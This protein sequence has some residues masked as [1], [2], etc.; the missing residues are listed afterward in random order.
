VL[1]VEVVPL[2]VAAET[3]AKGMVEEVAIP[4][5]HQQR[6]KAVVATLECHARS[7]ARQTMMHCS[8]GTGLIRH[9]KLKT[10]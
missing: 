8:V 9:I 1:F 3:V 4:A 10:Q 5:G 2:V 7:V 6:H